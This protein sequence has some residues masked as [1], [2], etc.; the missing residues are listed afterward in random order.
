MNK[1]PLLQWCPAAAGRGDQR[2][3]LAMPRNPPPPITIWV[4]RRC[5]PDSHHRCTL[6]RLPCLRR[7]AGGGMRAPRRAT[8]P[9]PRASRSR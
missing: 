7:S 8:C 5:P 9:R 4:P 3:T 2:S 6:G 1:T